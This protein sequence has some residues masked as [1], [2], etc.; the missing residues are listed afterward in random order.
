M[1]YFENLNTVEE[2]KEAYRK[3][4]K[5][6]HPDFGGDEEDFIELKNQY[7]AKLISFDVKEYPE[8]TSPEITSISNQIKITLKKNRV[9]NIKNGLKFTA[10]EMAVGLV[11]VGF[12]K[13]QKKFINVVD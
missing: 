7:E 5:E 4:A 11:E 10:S 3:Y 8:F 6:V 1:N 13:L 9:E 12:E 2:V